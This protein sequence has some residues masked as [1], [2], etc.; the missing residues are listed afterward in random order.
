M[1]VIRPIIA[2]V[3]TMAVVIVVRADD[4]S[5]ETNPQSHQEWMAELGYR[6]HGG[7]WRTAQEIAILERNERTNVAQKEWN[8]KIERLRRQLA[9]G[10]GAGRAAEELREIVD[11]YAVPALAA[12]LAAEPNRQVRLLYMESLAR[13]REPA[14]R[15][16]LV[17]AAVDH[18]D[19]ETRIDATE[20]LEAIAPQEAANALAAALAGTDNARTNRAAAALGRL[21]VATVVPQLIAVLETRHVVT[22]GDGPPE[23]STTA[24][25]TPEG[26]GL[27]LGNNR[28]QVAMPF[29]N[30]Q[31][32]EALVSLTGQNFG[33]DVSAWRAW[34]ARQRAPASIDLRRG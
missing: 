26:G 12:A 25:F 6:R 30:E 2:I 15:M 24:T 20:K 1:T 27:S 9:T 3:A 29:R 4:E 21:G 28:K 18:P 23:G 19:S 7:A 13:I 8:K 32:L 17:A 14:A 11:P 33:W 5:V 34:L 31:V 22:V 10:D 16:A